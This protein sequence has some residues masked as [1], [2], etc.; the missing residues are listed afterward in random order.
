MACDA[1]WVRGTNVS[2]KR[3]G[4]ETETGRPMGFRTILVE[5][6]AATLQ[7]PPSQSLVWG[8]G[9]CV[10]ARALAI[11]SAHTA[12]A[13]LSATMSALTEGRLSLNLIKQSI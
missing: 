4:D 12:I 3:D 6:A 8:H 7:P 13:S 11:L 2:I 1:G 5:L 9:V 10:R